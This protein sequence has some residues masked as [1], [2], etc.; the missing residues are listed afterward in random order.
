MCNKQLGAIQTS[1]IYVLSYH[2]G[3]S[4]LLSTHVLHIIDY[5]QDDLHQNQSENIRISNVLMIQIVDITFEN[6]NYV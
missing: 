3:V 4:K 1:R 6:E 2:I 5:W